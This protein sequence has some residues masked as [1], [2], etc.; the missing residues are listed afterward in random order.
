MGEDDPHPEYLPRTKNPASLMF[1]GV[2][3]STGE[4]CPPIWFPAGFRLLAVDYIAV[5]QCKVV[6]WMRRVAAAH[7]R[8]FCFHKTAP[9][10]TPPELP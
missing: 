5:L 6:P 1:L 10:P 7:A 4:V 3:A 8:P 2:I 9:P